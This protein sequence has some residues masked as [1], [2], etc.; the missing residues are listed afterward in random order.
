MFV[1]PHL[2]ECCGQHYCGGCIAKWL[3]TSASKTCPQCRSPTV[4]HILDRSVERKIREL[5][6]LCSNTSHGCTWIGSLCNLQR[7]HEK[8]PYVLTSCVH[9]CGVIVAR[10]DIEDHEKKMCGVRPV[11]CQFCAESHPINS[12]HFSSCPEQPVSCEKCCKMFPQ[13]QIQSHLESCT[14]EVCQDE[15]GS[16]VRQLVG[17]VAALKQEITAL[18]QQQEELKAELKSTRQKVADAKDEVS[19]L[20][21]ENK[22]V[23][24]ILLQELEFLHSYG[25]PHEQLALECIKTQLNHRVISLKADG[26]AATFRLLPYSQYKLGRTWYSS[27]FCVSDGYQLCI[28]VHPYG[29]GAGESSHVSLCLH[30]M[31]GEHDRHLKWPFVLQADFE[32]RLLRQ[33][34]G[35]DSPFSQQKK[36][37]NRERQVSGSDSPFS[38]QRKL[39]NSLNREHPSPD[40]GSKFKKKITLPPSG[41]AQCDL[42]HTQVAAKE[43]LTVSENLSQVVTGSKIG[44]VVSTLDLFC[45]Q[46][47]VENLV[48]KNSLVLQVCLITPDFRFA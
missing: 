4:T 28:A 13:S 24:S 48:H 19:S 9:G 1:E 43:I 31:K 10:R 14:K 11:Q 44:P 32:I 3:S 33:V 8:C 41:H 46:S 20:K 12:E 15:I 40:L 18:N 45:L 47:T 17:E 37:L 5:R 6:V 26:Q 16:A 34:S 38:Q 30:Q 23:K 42:R 29:L 22:G 7:H 21:A 39:F 36:R 2:T 35:S 27:P 25:Q